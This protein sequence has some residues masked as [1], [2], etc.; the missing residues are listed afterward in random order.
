MRKSCAE[1]EPL[2]CL[3]GVARGIASHDKLTVIVT[4]DGAT[5]AQHQTATFRLGRENAQHDYAEWGVRRQHTHKHMEDKRIS[6]WFS[7]GSRRFDFGVELLLE[8][9]TEDIPYTCNFV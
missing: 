6:Y 1:V 3:A 5:T 9:F 4:G 7:S 8:K 2:H